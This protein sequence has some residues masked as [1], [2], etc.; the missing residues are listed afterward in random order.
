[1]KGESVD[2]VAALLQKE[3]LE[4][5]GYSVT[6]RRKTHQSFLSMVHEANDYSDVVFAQRD[7]MLLEPGNCIPCAL[8]AHMGQRKEVTAKAM[9]TPKKIWNAHGLRTRRYAEW[10]DFSGSGELTF[11]P[12]VQVPT[13]TG[14]YLVHSG[15]LAS[16][17][18]VHLRIHGTACTITDGC[19][20]FHMSKDIFMAMC[21]KAVDHASLV[22]F[23]IGL[24]P[25]VDEAI[26]MQRSTLLNLNAGC[27]V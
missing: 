13:V 17:H 22:F 7:K 6:W 1:M 21:K 12:D 19:R 20:Q 14:G 24:K 9:E 25:P 16:P 18:C 26:I 11:F 10:T 8:A 4:H 2:D 5:T 3:V 15:G 27:F 23:A